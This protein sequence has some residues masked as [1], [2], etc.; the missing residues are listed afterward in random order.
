MA[1]Q[2]VEGDGHGYFRGAH[3]ASGLSCEPLVTS[4]NLTGHIYL[5]FCENARQDWLIPSQNMVINRLKYIASCII[6]YL[7][8]FHFL[9]E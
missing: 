6:S 4:I 8:C 9:G 3:W 2:R 5:K 1:M 7:N